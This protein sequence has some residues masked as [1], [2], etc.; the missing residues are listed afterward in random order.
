M[1]RPK[2]ER[3]PR[4]CRRDG[5]TPFRQLAFLAELVCSRSITEAARA[6][7]MSRESAYRLRRREPESLF[8][9]VW[10][11]ALQAPARAASKGHE[12]SASNTGRVRRRR[13]GNRG[14][15][16]MSNEG[17]KVDDPLFSLIRPQPL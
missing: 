13:V 9:A 2:S 5:W 10:D 16:P 12:L 11:R 17:H 15:A 3:T 8:A 7:G 14:F 1:D 4:S 6:A